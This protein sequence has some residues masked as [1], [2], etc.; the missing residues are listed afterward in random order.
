MRSR[1]L[2]LAGAVLL[3]CAAATTRAQAQ[4]YILLEVPGVQGE[5][6]LSAFANQIELLGASFAASNPACS[7]SSV[8]VS[9]LIVTKRTDKASVD[10]LVALKDKTVYPT[11]SVRFA[12]D[13]GGG[14]S[15]VVYQRYE[16]LDA[17]F[18]SVNSAG[19]PSDFRTV[20][21][22]TVSFNRA[23]VTY[24]FIDG[25][26]KPSSPESMTIIPATCPGS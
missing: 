4:Q 12:R 7:K 21:S 3:C 18:S 26:G 6:T 10:L 11:I 25:S 16:L 22:W 8:S 1:R 14:G 15:P 20:E 2:V 24:W 13:T 5:V 19:S 9:E 23:T 17:V